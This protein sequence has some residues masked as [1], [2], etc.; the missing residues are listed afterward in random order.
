MDQ[1]FWGFMIEQ[2]V[3]NIVKYRSQIDG[4]QTDPEKKAMD[5]ENSSSF[6]KMKEKI[7]EMKFVFSEM[8]Q[9]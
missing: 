3:E 7:K 6:I 1:K 4:L 8:L 9:G 2:T 5:C